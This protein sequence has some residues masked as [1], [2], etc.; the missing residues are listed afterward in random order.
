VFAALTIALP[1]L[2]LGHDQCRLSGVIDADEGIWCEFAGRVVRRLYR[3][4]DR[5]HRNMKG[6]QKSACQTAHQQ[7]APRDVA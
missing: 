6:K 3:L 1:H 4:V 5:T 7:R 2:D